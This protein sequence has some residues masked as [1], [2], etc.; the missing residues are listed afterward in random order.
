MPATYVVLDTNTWLHFAQP[1]AINWTDVVGVANPTIIVPYT[2]LQ[3][4]DE[5]RYSS[6]SEV[7]IRR[8]S[9]ASKLLATSIESGDSRFKFLTDSPRDWAQGRL[10]QS[11]AD[12]RLIAE[13]RA[14]P[15][16][17]QDRMIV[18]TG[19]VALRAKLKAFKIA[20][21]ELADQHRLPDEADTALRAAKSKLAKIESASPN[22]SASFDDGASH[23]QL[24]LSPEST[25]SDAEIERRRTAQRTAHYHPIDASRK[26]L[27]DDDAQAKYDERWRC[28]DLA[29][30][31]Y[32]RAVARI[33]HRRF[34]LTFALSNTGQ[35][36]GKGVVVTFIFPEDV[37]VRW[38][39]IF[40]LLL[41]PGI[42]QTPPLKGEV[43]PNEPFV[44]AAEQFEAL[45]KRDDPGYQWKRVIELRLPSRTAK[46]RKNDSG[47]ILAWYTLP[48]VDQGETTLLRTLQIE[49]PDGRDT[50]PFSVEWTAHAENMVGADSGTLV[51]S[52]VAASGG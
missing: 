40:S 24:V 8:A 16:A 30:A 1:A 27:Y 9:V 49:L 4:L 22:F 11:V 10:Q 2:V 36:R 21:T 47:A 14:V 50:R 42:P 31:A 6:R 25:V 48:N 45:A 23:V 52:F 46:L 15:L 29:H 13:I 43:R 37:R 28:Y 32:L 35:V 17:E 41:A 3:E 38:K 44:A 39:P 5:K 33:E 26:E 12:D 20:A 19:D 18:V 34:G 7:L 51:V